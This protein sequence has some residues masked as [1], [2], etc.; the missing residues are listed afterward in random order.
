[1]GRI[2][3]RTLLLMMTALVSGQQ[4]EPGNLFFLRQMRLVVPD[5]SDIPEDTLPTPLP[6]WTPRAMETRQ[7]VHRVCF[8]FAEEVPNVLQAEALSLLGNVPALK[9]GQTC[10]GDNDLTI[11]V[12]T[13]QTLEEEEIL[14]QCPAHT[15]ARMLH[16]LSGQGRGMISPIGIALYR[17]LSL[18]GIAFLHP[19]SPH[20]PDQ[21]TLPM[22]DIYIRETPHLQIR[23]IHLH[24]MHPLEFTDF[25]NGW[26]PAGIED[27][28]GFENT[29]GNWK[30]FLVWMLANGM[31]RVQWALLWNQ[32]WADFADSP[33]RKKRLEQIV[34][35]AHRF[36]VEVGIDA[37]VSLKQQNA[38][39][40]V[41]TVGS[42]PE[43]LAQIRER[44]D[45]LMATGID[46]LA[47]ES[48]T[49]E[50]T[51]ASPRRMLE[52]LN[53]IVA[54]LDEKYAKTATIKVHVS[55]GQRAGDF[56]DPVFKNALNVNFLPSVADPRLG[57]MPHTVGYYGLSDPAPVYGNRDFT[58]MDAY[59][60]AEVGKREVIWYPESAYWC[61]MDVDVPLF[62]PVYAERRMHDLRHLE[63]RRLARADG[64]GID[65]E[66]IFSSG[67]EWGFWLGDV[68][69]ARAAWNPMMEITDDDT[70]FV[71]Q[72][73]NV[74]AP[75]DES[76]WPMAALVAQLAFAQRE[77][78]IWGNT[79]Q[80]GESFDSALAGQAYL[81][82][83]EPLDE[84]AIYLQQVPGAPLTG[85]QPE[86][87]ALFP[88]GR[89]G[90]LTSSHVQQVGML[91]RQMKWT[92][93]TLYHRLAQ[94]S[95]GIDK[96]ARWLYS[97]IS[98]GLNITH[99]R[100][101]QM[102]ALFHFQLAF[103]N[104]DFQRTTQMAALSK[105]LIDEALRVVRHRELFYRMP[106]SF[107]SSRRANPTAYEFG[108]LWTVHDLYYWRRD[109]L[110]VTTQNDNPCFANIYD[111]FLLAFGT[112]A[113][114][115]RVSKVIA[116]LNRV[117]KL[118]WQ[119]CLTLEPLPEKWVD[120]TE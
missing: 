77:L 107:L 17:A 120:K 88:G 78:L 76:A 38:Y 26:G 91:L 27:E 111:P 74:L 45:Y 34:A 98:D 21:A 30:S 73:E 92:F 53:Y 84:M 55:S 85:T 8:V 95:D 42:L 28:T 101:A 86:R 116:L 97:E 51:H 35:M 15:G 46:F 49:S 71:A 114:E 16:V 58:H 12:G 37:P 54:Y 43:E 112:P 39:R 41:R 99:L 90:G 47:L 119:S 36:G 5:V 25:L 68:V 1:M 10:S 69:A 4:P 11:V 117:T 110:K 115:S 105:T 59:I 64:V 14:L 18:L 65:G 96:D 82:G 103:A 52:R 94:L 32:R 81:Q 75:F 70:A 6:A 24:T 60:Q 22:D 3:R 61:S 79:K 40:L 19:L 108:Y 104:D 13:S 56:V 83:V 102:E 106:V 20:I 48:G 87:I 93:A 57:V 44:I 29:M 9:T 113:A 50:F 66:V 31:N 72:L 2:W 89:K 118:D 7:P 67:W 62:L 63:H 23:G 109:H 80:A 100:A 33:L